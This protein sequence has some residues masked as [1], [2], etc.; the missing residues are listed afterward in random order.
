MFT[1]YFFYLEEKRIR[2]LRQGESVNS[3]GDNEAGTAMEPPQEQRMII[4]NATFTPTS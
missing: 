3:Q 4:T 1:L 2:I